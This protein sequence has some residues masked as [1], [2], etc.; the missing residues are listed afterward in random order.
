M[1]KLGRCHNLG[2]E[3]IPWGKFS[4]QPVVLGLVIHVISIF[5]LHR[6]LEK[7]HSWKLFPYGK[8]FA[9][10]KIK[11]RRKSLVK[12]GW[13]WY[14]A[15]LHACV[16]ISNEEVAFKPNLP[17]IMLKTRFLSFMQIPGLIKIVILKAFVRSVVLLLSTFSGFFHFYR[18]FCRPP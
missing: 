9:H 8:I 2:P 15:E 17:F 10:G 13:Y 1:N 16:Q 7:I 4:R 11:S 5:C 12:S 3:L 14:L 18:G 6:A